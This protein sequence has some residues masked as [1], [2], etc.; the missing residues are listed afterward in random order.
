LTRLVYG[1]QFVCGSIGDLRFAITAR[2]G[3]GK[4]A[5]LCAVVLEEP[6]MSRPHETL[7]RRRAGSLLAGLLV[8][9]S[10]CSHRIPVPGS[11]GSADLAALDDAGQTCA[12]LAPRAAAALE[13]AAGLFRAVFDP[14]LSARALTIRG[15]RSGTSAV[16]FDRA[17]LRGFALVRPSPVGTAG[18]PVAAMAALLAQTRVAVGGT[19]SVRSS[20]TRTQSAQHASTKEAVWQIE[21]AS[22]TDAAHVRR[23]LLAALLDVPADAL[24]GLPATP[25]AAETRALVVKLSLALW[26]QGIAVSAALAAQR[27]FDG[28]GDALSAL[29]DDL[30]NG[31]ALAPAGTRT[32]QTCDSAAHP[33]PPAAD[34]LFVVDESGSMFDNREDIVNHA[35]AFFAKAQAASL[36]F[37]VGVAGMKDPAKAPALGKLCSAASNDPTDPGGEDRFLRP[38]E[39]ALFSACV[40]NPPYFEGGEEFGLAHGYHAVARHL[41]RAEGD[42]QRIRS[43]AKLA[44]IFVTDETAQELKAG[45]S[46]EGRTGFLE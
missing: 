43:G 42:P 25:A 36:D 13:D 19:V 4:T 9:L 28:G 3:D 32:E 10:G 26:G 34:I 20:G 39:Q 29:V 12:G 15:A 17:P 44:L 27:D 22:R 45:S 37:R 1:L 41:P 8:A 40:R 11:D 16:V 33:G 35:N 21:T 18:D 38:D 7:C 31:T 5:P 6:V 24:G 2:L 30:G 14:R 46:Y 23:A